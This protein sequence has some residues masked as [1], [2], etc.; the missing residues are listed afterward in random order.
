MHVPISVLAFFDEQP[1]ARK[2]Q[3]MDSEGEIR[4]NI[5]VFGKFFV[6]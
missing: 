6:R 2:P 4:L 5:K 1:V 3:E